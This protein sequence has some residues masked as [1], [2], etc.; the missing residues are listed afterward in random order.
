MTDTDLK[1]EKVKSLAAEKCGP[2]IEQILIDNFPELEPDKAVELAYHDRTL[3]NLVS[4]YEAKQ[5]F[6]EIAKQ[7]N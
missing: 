3:S 4:I 2:I 6:E 5:G 1:M 7:E